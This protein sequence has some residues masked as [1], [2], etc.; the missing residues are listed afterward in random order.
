MNDEDNIEL[1][2]KSKSQG[3][4]WYFHSLALKNIGPYRIVFRATRGN[5]NKSEIA[6]DDFFIINTVC[7]KVNDTSDTSDSA[8]GLVVGLVIGGLLLACVVIVIV[9]LVRRQVFKSRPREKIRNNLG[10]N[11]Y[12]GVQDIALP[13]TA[14][15]ASHMENDT[16]SSNTSVRGF[17][18]THA[19]AKI[20]N[21]NKK[22]VQAPAYA[23]HRKTT[24]S[25]NQS[26]NDDKY[27]IVDQTAET[28]FNGNIDDETG[29]A[30]SYMV[31]DPTET[32]FKR[33]QCSNIAS[34]YEFVKPV[35]DT[36]NKIGDEDQYALS[37]DG[38]Y[39]HSG[40]NRHKELENNIYNH[41]V[42]T[43]YDSGCHKRNDEGREDTY[44]HFF[45]QKTE[46]D[47]DI[48]TTT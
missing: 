37:E 44:D 17:D 12:I 4:K 30:D 5:G 25:D 9:V 41:A 31:L 3:N 36:G 20:S 47:Y 33:T 42:D 23:V 19:H 24:S 13:L 26:L 35:K 7:K 29:T 32:G 48:S 45:G 10:A 28:S 2:N 1:W 15:H 39:D 43:I 40:N 18:S 21:V 27:S 11:D 8:T 6:V 22:R 16:H 34:G 38:V 46:D 14:N